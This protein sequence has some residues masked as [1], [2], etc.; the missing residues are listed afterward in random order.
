ML[1]AFLKASLQPVKVT[2]VEARYD[3]GF[4]GAIAI[5]PRLAWAAGLTEF[6][7]VQVYNVVRRESHFLHVLFGAEAAVEIWTSGPH[8]TQR[9]DT[10][11]ITA[12]VWLTPNE[13]PNHAA[14]LALLGKQN[15]PIEIRRI[16]A[17]SVPIDPS[18]APLPPRREDTHS[19]TPSSVI[20][21]SPAMIRA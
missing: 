9:G 8:R 21:A 14:T 16:R 17:R 6:E 13:I 1:A 2:A 18:F 4:D 11:R 10:L 12:F 20:S 19:E 15:T 7:R 3:L 5:G